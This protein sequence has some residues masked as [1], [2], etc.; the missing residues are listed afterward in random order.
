MKP[1]SPI[2]VF[3]LAL[4]G[5]VTASTPDLEAPQ[6]PW[7][8]VTPDLCVARGLST[9]SSN[10]QESFD[11]LGQLGVT[12]LRGGLHWHR[13]EPVPGEFDFSAYEPVVDDLLAM[14]V[15]PLALLAYG[16]P[17]ASDYPDA[18]HFYPPEDPADF[19]AYAGA[20]AEHFAGRIRRYE[21]WNEQN[22]GYRFWKPELSGD[23]V[24]YGR[25]FA[26]AAEAIHVADP[27]AQVSIGGTFFHD[28]FI[29]GSLEFLASMEPEAWASADALAFH[30]Y[31]F[32]PP[33]VP[34]EYAGSSDV[35]LGTGEIP[36]IEMIAKLRAVA[37][38]AG[39]TD[40]PLLVTEFGWPSWGEVDMLEQADWAERSVLLGLSQGVSTWC[41]YTIF[42]REPGGAE[43]RFGMAEPSGVLTPYGE[44]M[45]D[46]AEHLAGVEAAAILDL[47]EAQHGVVLRGPGE[48]QRSIVWGSGP[49]A[50]DDGTVVELGPTPVGW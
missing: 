46:L 10:L 29:M 9:S 35:S 25:L 42:N 39:R 8:E 13:I 22:A 27:T 40:I 1:V 48:Q 31:T 12:S 23:P 20:T 24:A 19:A 15:E 37:A 26:Q 21:I 50:L 33:S 14:G 11:V 38:D 43:D 3:L 7:V 45:R 49:L 36:L 44:R 47:P 16:N 32:Y 4:T 6:L 18:D 30:P 17:W 41:G 28:Q 5:C 34:P 2:V